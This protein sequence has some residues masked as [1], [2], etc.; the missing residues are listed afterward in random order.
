MTLYRT[1]NP[2]EE[3]LNCDNSLPGERKSNEVNLA[4]K[5]T[6]GAAIGCRESN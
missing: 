1:P 6:N 4:V 3:G 2:A 5:E